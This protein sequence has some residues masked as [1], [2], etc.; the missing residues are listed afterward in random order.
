MTRWLV[1]AAILLFIVAQMTRL[2]PSKRD[3]QLQALRA[4]AGRAGLSVRFWASRTSGY[5]LRQLPESGYIYI[6]PWPLPHSVSV[7]WALWLDADGSTSTLAGEP[8]AVARDWLVAFRQ[9]FPDGWALLETGEAGLCV[10]WQERGD[11]L[12]VEHLAQALDL[13]RKSLP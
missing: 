9:R 11:V 6:L 7:R 10:L 12:D 4:A 13:L 5:K 3:Q 1:L 8:P 2:R